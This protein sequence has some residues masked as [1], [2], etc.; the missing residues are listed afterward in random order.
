MNTR[1][2]KY[3]L[4]GSLTLLLAVPAVAY[5]QRGAA[6]GPGGPG[7][8]AVEQ[9]R[10]EGTPAQRRD[11]APRGA[12]EGLGLQ[13]SPRRGG[14]GVGAGF[15]PGVAAR[16]MGAGIAGRALAHADEIGLSDEQRDRILASQ[17]AV[18]EASINRRAE[19]DI[20]RLR[21]G[22]LLGA[23]DRDI[24]EIEA[25]LRELADMHVAQQVGVL[26]ADEEVRGVLSAE[27]IETL[28]E[29]PRARPRSADGRPGRA[30]RGPAR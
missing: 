18:R 19:I 27:Q 8:G 30:R 4:I 23:D 20:A 1:L 28:E 6:G 13:R 9:G 14:A 24:A 3:S 21:L 22:E 15:G 25:K 17:R 16:R 12:V 11:R 10:F 26:R 5:S 7:F 2:V 29:L